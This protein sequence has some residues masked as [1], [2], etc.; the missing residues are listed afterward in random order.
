MCLCWAEARQWYPCACAR[1]IN[2]R[3]PLLGSV[4]AAT[5]PARCGAAA[6]WSHTRVRLGWLRPAC[7]HAKAARQRRLRARMQGRRG[8]GRSPEHPCARTM[9]LLLLLARAPTGGNSEVAAPARWSSEEAVTAR[10]LHASAS[11]TP[12]LAVLLLLFVFFYVLWM[13][14]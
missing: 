7:R 3:T 9:R 1:G 4:E 12:T 14:Q 6:Q 5:A 8:S 2:T 13:M 10:L 11:T